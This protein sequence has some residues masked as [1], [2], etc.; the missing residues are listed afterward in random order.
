MITGSKQIN[1]LNDFEEGGGGGRN[2]DLKKNVYVYICFYAGRRVYAGIY[3]C[4]RSANTG[5]LHL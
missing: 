2:V 3:T 1:F 5:V 4:V